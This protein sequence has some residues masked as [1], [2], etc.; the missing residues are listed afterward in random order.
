MQ[1]VAADADGHP[2]A[3][4]VLEGHARLLDVQCQREREE[5]SV[6]RVQRWTRWLVLTA[7]VALLAGR[8]GAIMEC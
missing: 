1:A 4:A 8:G 6:L 2:L 5:W 7:V 3:R